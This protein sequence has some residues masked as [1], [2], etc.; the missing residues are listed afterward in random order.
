MSSV[1]QIRKELKEVFHT[2]DYGTG[3]YIRT[4]QFNVVQSNMLMN[5]VAEHKLHLLWDVPIVSLYKYYLCI[6]FLILLFI[7][8]IFIKN[9]CIGLW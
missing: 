9:N 7:F 4:Q 5:M 1:T 2:D 6:I 8:S 3:L